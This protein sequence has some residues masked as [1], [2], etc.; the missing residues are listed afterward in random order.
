MVAQLN[1]MRKK[2]NQIDE[3]WEAYRTQW[4]NYLDKATQM[5]MSHVESYEQ[6]EIKFAE[7]RSE[8]LQN[9]KTTRAALIP[10]SGIASR[11]GSSSFKAEGR[12]GT[13]LAYPY[14]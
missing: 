12:Q 5:W 6:G 4:A 11:K 9:L 1:T 7:R 3:E 10:P 13:I 14:L 2:L 8:A